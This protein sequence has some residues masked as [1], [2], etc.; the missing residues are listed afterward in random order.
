MVVFV[1]DGATLGSCKSFKMNIQEIINKYQIEKPAYMKH[2]T[3]QHLQMK[4]QFEKRA[5]KELLEYCSDHLFN[6]KDEQDPSRRKVFKTMFTLDGQPLETLKDLKE[7][8]ADATIL[9]QKKKVIIH[10]DDHHFNDRAAEDAD[11][12]AIVKKNK[13]SFIFNPQISDMATEL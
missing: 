13:A 7:Y 12:S 5:Y 10:D 9:R 4:A 3:Q 11:P 6:Q 8:C 2:V 1:K